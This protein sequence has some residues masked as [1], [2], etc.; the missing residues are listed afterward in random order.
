ML[1]LVRQWRTMS[2]MNH[3]KRYMNNE[4]FDEL[5]ESMKE[6]VSISK[7][8]TEPS[9]VFS[10]SPMNIKE[11][12]ERTGKSQKDFADMIGVSLGTLRN[13]E[14]GRRYPEGAALTLL[15]VVSADP[16]YVAKILHC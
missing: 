10:Y 13:W 9:R 5:V 14:Q 6:A 12:R 1:T 2:N 15:K 11:I 16:A 3:D 8:E 7:G 4:M